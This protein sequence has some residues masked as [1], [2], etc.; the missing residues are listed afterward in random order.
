MIVLNSCVNVLTSFQYDHDLHS[1]SVVAGALRKLPLE[2]SA[3]WFNHVE[4]VQLFQPGLDELSQWL[5]R[6]SL[7]QEATLRTVGNSQTRN[8]GTDKNKTS[9]FNSVVDNVQ[10]KDECSL[11][12][13]KHKI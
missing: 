5:C 10:A 1:E 8:D 2:W 3:K 13:G 11:K 12:D 7:A 6:K 4:K 9:S